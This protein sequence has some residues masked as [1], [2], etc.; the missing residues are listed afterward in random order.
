MNIHSEAIPESLKQVIS[1]RNELTRVVTVAYS[2]FGKQSI[3]TPYINRKQTKCSN[4]NYAVEQYLE[5]ACRLGRLPFNSEKKFNANGGAEHVE[6]SN[7]KCVITVHSVKKPTQAPRPA[8]FRKQLISDCQGDL[9]KQPI[10]DSSIVTPPKYYIILTHGGG[11]S[12]ILDFICVGILLQEGEW[13]HRKILFTR[14][15]NGVMLPQMFE[16]QEIS[17]EQEPALRL[18]DKYLNHQDRKNGE[19]TT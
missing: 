3:E 15:L 16:E 8:K 11:S 10:S 9:F 1:Y 7:D 19:G 2:A 18:K 13:L 6:F 14:D 5:D 4:R 17:E 12:S